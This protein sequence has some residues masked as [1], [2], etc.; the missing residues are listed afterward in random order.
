MMV[1]RPS[2]PPESWRT[3]R[4]LPSL[5]LGVWMREPSAA[6]A[7]ADIVRS[8]KV[9]TVGATASSERPLRRKVRR[10]RRGLFMGFTPERGTGF[11]PVIATIAEVRILFG[12]AKKHGLKTRATFG[13]Q[14]WYSGIETI[15]WIMR[16]V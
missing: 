11:Q 8:R 3:M 10:V 16:R 1:L 12:W 5:P 9:G 6:R 14:S 15:N 7:R 13:Q 4:I 2:L